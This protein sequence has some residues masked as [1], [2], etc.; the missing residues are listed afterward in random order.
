MVLRFEV[1]QAEA[2]RQGIDVE[3][4]T[5][6]LNVD[7]SKLSQEDRN[8]IA[9]RLEGI[10]VCE[11]DEEGQ[12]LFHEK[13][14]KNPITNWLEHEQTPARIEAKLPTFEAL[15]EA[16]RENEKKVTRRPAKNGKGAK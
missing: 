3:K 4:S 8:L 5:N 16:I 12:K 11:L 13:P 1:N 6:H 14:V 9:D 15:M 2:F 7:P 10:D